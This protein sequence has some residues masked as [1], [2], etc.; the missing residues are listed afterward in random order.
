MR[1]KIIE[2]LEQ[3]GTKPIELAR[4][5]W[6][7]ANTATQR[8]LISKWMI[9]PPVSIRLDQLKALSE[10]F[11]TTDINRLIDFDDE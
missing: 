8:S 7:E 3:T 4:I 9:R 1:I 2:L 11:V 6:P 10:F 5:L